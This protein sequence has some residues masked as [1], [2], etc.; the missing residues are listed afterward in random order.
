MSPPTRRAVLAAVGAAVTTAGCASEPIRPATDETT[1]SDPAAADPTATD[2]LLAG[3]NDPDPDHAITVVNRGS[4]SRRVRVRV[5]REAAGEAVFEETVD[6]PPDGEREVYNL[7]DAAPDGIE[8]FEVCGELDG[9]ADARDCATLRTN[10]CY[11]DAHVTVRSDESVR[12][13]YSVY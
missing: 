6:A 4:E 9:D 7:A 5:V 10:A 13:V 1:A 3:A 2:G 12:V 8:S 11:G